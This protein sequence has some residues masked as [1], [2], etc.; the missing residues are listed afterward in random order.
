M[1]L[2][3]GNVMYRYLPERA[4]S[5][6]DRNTILSYVVGLSNFGFVQIAA[7][8]PTSLLLSPLLLLLRLLNC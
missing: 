5:P 2:S 4:K 8:L 7:I 6:A 1:W 3:P